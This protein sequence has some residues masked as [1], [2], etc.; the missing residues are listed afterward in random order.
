MTIINKTLVTYHILQFHLAMSFQPI[1]PSMYVLLV[2]GVSTIASWIDT[3]RKR[4]ILRVPHSGLENISRKR[5]LQ[6][7]CALWLFLGTSYQYMA[8]KPGLSTLFLIL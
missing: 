4:G 5:F 1:V 7:N 2:Y 6:N 8:Y 3:N